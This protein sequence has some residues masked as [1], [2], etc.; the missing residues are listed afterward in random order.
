VA[1]LE[2][3]FHVMTVTVLMSVVAH[4]VSAAPLTRRMGQSDERP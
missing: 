4:G 2:Q 3:I 1:G